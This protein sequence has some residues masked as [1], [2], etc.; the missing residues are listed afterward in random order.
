MCNE[1]AVQVL[2]C[3]YQL[4]QEARGLLFIKL[5]LANNIVEQF[6]AFDVLHDEVDFAFGFQDLKDIRVNEFTSYN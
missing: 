5:A 1:I 3:I 2:N 6:T 4:L